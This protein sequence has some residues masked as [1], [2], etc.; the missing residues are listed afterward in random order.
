MGSPLSF[1]TH[2][3]FMVDHEATEA[4]LPE[5]VRL[6]YDGLRVSW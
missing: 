1:L 2:M 3:T 6:A 4:E 5:N